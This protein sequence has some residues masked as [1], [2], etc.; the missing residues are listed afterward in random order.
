MVSK[1]NFGICEVCGGEIR[2]QCMV[3]TGVCC[4]NCEKRRDTQ[5]AK[6]EDA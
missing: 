2:M 5:G 1:M 6:K 4:G 3:A